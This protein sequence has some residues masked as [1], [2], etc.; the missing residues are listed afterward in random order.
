[1]NLQTFPFY[2]SLDQQA[3]FISNCGQVTRALP[4]PQN[5]WLP[6]LLQLPVSGDGLDCVRIIRAADDVLYRTVASTDFSYE[7]FSDGNFDF[8]FYYGGIV[9]GLNMPCDDYYLETKGQYSEVFSVVRNIDKFLRLEWRNPGGIYQTGFFNLL[10]LDTIVAE[11][12]YPTEEEGEEDASG[13][14]VALQVSVEKTLK[15]DTL[16]LPE[17]LV[18]ALAGIPLHKIKQIGQ[19]SEVRNVKIKPEW[20]LAGCAATVEVTFADGAALTSES[21]GAGPILLPVDLSGF[22][23]SACDGSG[24]IWADAGETRC[25]QKDGTN[26]GWMEKKQKDTNALSASFNQFRW[27]RTQINETACPLPAKMLKSRAISEQVFRTNCGPNQEAGFVIYSIPEGQFEGTDQAVIDKQ[28][29]DYFEATKELYANS[30]AVCTDVKKVVIKNIRNGAKLV[31]FDLVRND[32]VGELA[33]T[34]EAQ[35]E[36]QLAGDG[37]DDV[38][39]H[40]ATFIIPAGQGSKVGC[41]IPF[42]PDIIQRVQS[43]EII[44]TNP[45]DYSY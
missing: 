19:Y 41:S 25:E 30:N 3:R 43:A 6:F 29:R 23:P 36:V 11:P 4:T 34:V 37:S 22:T 17:Y 27:V 9:A 10:Y 5:R 42:G 33:V 12:Q 40:Q 1:M 18:D 38:L 28:A 32:T 44:S 7:V 2:S 26:T 21:C 13:N 24:P 39:N 14:F 45:S 16:L 35:A 20:N 15:L 31:T 8:V